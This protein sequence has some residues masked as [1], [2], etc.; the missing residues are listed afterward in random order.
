MILYHFI[1]LNENLSKRMKYVVIG[2]SGGTASGSGNTLR[3]V[4]ERK[5]KQTNKNM[6]SYL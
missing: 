3:S 4:L 6:I 2:G 5:K 1:L